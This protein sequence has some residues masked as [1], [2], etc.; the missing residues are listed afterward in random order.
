MLLFGL[1]HEKAVQLTAHYR[2][3]HDDGIGA[4]R[5]AANGLRLPVPLP[6]FVQEN[7]ASQARALGIESGR[8][9][10]DVVVAR[11]A[12]RELE[13][14]Q[15]EGFGGEQAQQIL[16][17]RTHEYLRYHGESPFVR[18]RTEPRSSAPDGEP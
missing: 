3:C 18:A 8:T 10:V 9:A 7:L 2:N 4:H 5:Q 17:R 16:T 14:T 15:P 12:G 11:T 6:D 13:L 1:P